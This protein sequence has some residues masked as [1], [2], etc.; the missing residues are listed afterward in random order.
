MI[1]RH[2]RLDR[3]SLVDEQRWPGI[4]TFFRGSGAASLIAP[5]WLLTAAHVARSIPPDG[6]FSVE[7]GRKPYPIARAILHPTF[8]PQWETEDEI[9]EHDIVDLALAELQMPV[10]NITPFELYTRSDEQGQELLL[11]GCGE[12]GKGMPGRRSFDRALRQVTNQ[13]DEANA[14]WLKFCFDAPP[15]G[16]YLEGVCGRGDSG[17]PAFIQH[18]NRLLLAGVSSWQRTEGRPMGTYGCVEHYARV[19]CF[20][21][22]IQSTAALS[23]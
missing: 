16:T 19:S 6:H 18:N 10:E 21:E 23:L 7:L 1:I 3:E 11:L 13:V 14:Y 12:S 15:A 9:N 5:T 17:G 4:T 8:D 20:L 22:W 2:D